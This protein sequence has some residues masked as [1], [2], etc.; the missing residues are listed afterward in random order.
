MYIFINDDLEKP[1]TIND[2][3]ISEFH[4]FIK[5]I[6]I[7]I[8]KYKQKSVHLDKYFYGKEIYDSIDVSDFISDFVN[9]AIKTMCYT[10]LAKCDFIDISTLDGL[11]LD[12]TNGKKDISSTIIGACYSHNLNKNL[13]ICYSIDKQTYNQDTFNI[14]Y[15]NDKYEILNFNV[16]NHGEIYNRTDE[17][18]KLIAHNSISSWTDTLNY[19]KEFCSAVFLCEKCM[20]PMYKY[21]FNK[22]VS[23][24]IIRLIEILNE[25]ECNTTNNTLTEYGNRIYQ[26]NF[27][28][29]NSN[30]S[31]EKGTFNFDVT[32]SNG[33]KATDNYPYHGKI[34]SEH[35]P[36]RIHFTW[37]RKDDQPI[38]I[39]YIGTKLTKK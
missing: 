13:S 18:K 28:Q 25:I 15:G 6:H 24:N 31:S 4:D 12:T 8:E 34:E 1:M 5:I 9:G 21:P 17:H 38:N 7:H 20:E 36:I 27:N 35:D 37:P 23:N 2:D 10:T 11:I 39:L 30:F 29:Q 14:Y 19:C 26:E 33:E 3:N 16:N 32:L 22:A